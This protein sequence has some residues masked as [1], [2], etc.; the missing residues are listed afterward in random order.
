MNGQAG[1]NVLSVVDWESNIDSEIVVEMEIQVMKVAKIQ[2]YRWK[3]VLR[4]SAQ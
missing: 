2:R 1:L 4:K 3:L